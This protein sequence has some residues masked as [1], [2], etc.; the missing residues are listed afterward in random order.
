MN[1]RR[2]LGKRGEDLAKQYLQNK[3]YIIIEENYRSGRNEIDIIAQK[4]DLIAFVEV[5]TRTS[6]LYGYPEE[7]LSSKQEE[8]IRRAAQDYIFKTNW[9]KHIRFDV[10]AILITATRTEI[11]HFPDAIY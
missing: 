10:I 1:K 5:K 6:A 2:Q 9:K 8:C 3:N 11:R 7:G 4:D